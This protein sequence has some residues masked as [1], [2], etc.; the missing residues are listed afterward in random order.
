M[1]IAS[2]RAAAAA[3]RLVTR[4][5]LP[6]VVEDV[7][8]FVIAGQSQPLGSY[9]TDTDVMTFPARTLW[10]VNVSDQAVETLVAITTEQAPG[11]TR[12]LRNSIAP[13]LAKQWKARTGR[14]AVVMMLA[15]QASCLLATTPGV[16]SLDGFH[17]DPAGGELSFA[18]TT[19]AGLRDPINR[20]DAI[21]MAL[22]R[23]DGS[24]RFR[25]GKTFLIW[26]QGGAEAQ[27]I[28]ASGDITPATYRAALQRLWDFYKGQ[29]VSRMGIISYGHPG[30]APDAAAVARHKMLW[31]AQEAFV[32]AN[33][34][35]VMLSIA[36]R[37][38]LTS[39]DPITISH[40]ITL[41]ENGHIAPGG[42][43]LQTDNIHW[44]DDA[45]TPLGTEC[46]DTLADAD[47]YPQ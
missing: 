40:T 27:H 15:W 24:P 43:P 12:I 31:G 26:A 47:G 20:R 22:D 5:F 38:S 45:I 10:G 35:A 14:N 36:P 42:F 41:D 44:G 30:A 19:N 32:A 33:A 17:W 13:A 28:A 34:D 29:G 4:R 1:S 7:D 9:G 6:G 2:R 37:Y 11:T 16:N 23:M 3:D 8:L 46:A 18:A 39:E 21:S 25:I